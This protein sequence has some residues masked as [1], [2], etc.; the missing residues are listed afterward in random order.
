MR[1]SGQVDYLECYGVTYILDCV[2]RE[3]IPDGP[4][5]FPHLP[6]EIFYEIPHKPLDILVGNAD[7]R[8]QPK[9]PL[10]FGNCSDCDL[11]R[12]CYKL[13]YAPGW[14]VSRRLTSLGSVDVSLSLT[15]RKISLCKLRHW[16]L[17]PLSS[18]PLVRLH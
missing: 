17:L 12:C 14:V 7:I 18:A 11:N 4:A 8:V 13:W 1:M 9:C 16:V 5:T 6:K 3:A 2:G 10:G 15:I